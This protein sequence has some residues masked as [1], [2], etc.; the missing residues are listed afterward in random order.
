MT[1]ADGTPLSLKGKF[2]QVL[3]EVTKF[4][5][6]NWQGTFGGSKL[7]TPSKIDAITY[8]KPFRELLYGS[9][10]SSQ[11]AQM[12]A[13]ICAQRQSDTTPTRAG[14]TTIKHFV[15]KFDKELGQQ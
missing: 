9:G 8:I 12:L 4:E 1:V 7:T 13:S 11:T 10:S 6:Q 15:R 2:D 3:Q 5:Y 14:Q